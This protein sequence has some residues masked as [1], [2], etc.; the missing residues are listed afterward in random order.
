M[1]VINVVKNELKS[2]DTR[3]YVRSAD[4]DK[5]NR[6]QIMLKN[7]NIL[8]YLELVLMGFLLDKTKMDSYIL[9]KLSWSKTTKINNSKFSIRRKKK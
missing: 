3:T 2:N 7:V 6:N 4:I 9:V 8:K 5:I 1:T